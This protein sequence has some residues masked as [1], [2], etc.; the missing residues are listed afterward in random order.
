MCYPLPEES[1]E[2][3]QR[4]IILSQFCVLAGTVHS[5]RRHEHGTNFGLWVG[6]VFHITFIPYFMNKPR[7]GSPCDFFLYKAEQHC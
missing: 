1:N 4:N 3:K 6:F 7:H 2:I 5:K